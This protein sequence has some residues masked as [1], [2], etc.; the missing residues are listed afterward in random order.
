MD[1][2]RSSQN[3]PSTSCLPYPPLQAHL[4]GAITQHGVEANLRL[5]CI[6][7]VASKGSTVRIHHGADL[8]TALISCALTLTSRSLAKGHIPASMSQ[9]CRL[10]WI[11]TSENVPPSRHFG[12]L[13]T[14]ASFCSAF[15]FTTQSALDRDVL[16]AE[17]AHGDAAVTACLSP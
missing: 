10:F 13:Q 4:S 12:T 8:F 17:L 16:D 1:E 9:L 14:L 11:W 7:G 6:L 5:F 15:S 3:S 2:R